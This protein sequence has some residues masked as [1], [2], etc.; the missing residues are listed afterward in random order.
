MIKEQVDKVYGALCEQLGDL[1]SKISRLQS[2]KLELEKKIEGILSI[3]PEL[4]ALDI[5]LQR[6]KSS[7]LQESANESNED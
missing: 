1:D 3:T 5:S 2:Q 6:Q 4:Y 7:K